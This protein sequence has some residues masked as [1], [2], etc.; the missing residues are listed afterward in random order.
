MECRSNC[1]ACCIAPSI[2]SLNK[3]AGVACKHLTS[4]L[5][6]SIFGS[7]GR[8]QVCSDFK[9][10]PEFCGQDRN[11]AMQILNFLENETQST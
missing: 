6:C 4:D 8:P 2:S 7:D 3:P 9:P 1:A 10:E 5:R 11:Q